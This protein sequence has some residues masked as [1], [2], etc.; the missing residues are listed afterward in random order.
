MTEANIINLGIG[1]SSVVFS[2][3]GAWGLI[4]AGI[5]ENTRRIVSLES[6][7]GKIY[8]ELKAQGKQVS[9]IDAKVDILLERNK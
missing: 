7:R 9:S 5:K 8:D 6:S 3:G 1:I 2:I 4:R